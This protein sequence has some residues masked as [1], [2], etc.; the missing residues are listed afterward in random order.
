M[1]Y[2]YVRVSMEKQSVENQRYQLLA[3]AHEKHM[4]IDRWIEESI[5]SRKKLQDR[6]LSALLGR[7]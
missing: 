5:R 4:M 1:I 2:A 6:E 3:F 7:L